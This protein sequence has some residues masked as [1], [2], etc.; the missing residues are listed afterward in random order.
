MAEH[1]NGDF[2]AT[3]L[4]MLEI[5]SDGLPHTRQELHRCL[6]DEEG[7][8]SN[9]NVHLTHMRKILARRGESIM[10]VE[11]RTLYRLVRFVQNES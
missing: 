3:E 10:C 8:L 5:L 7:P 2:T 11:G 4:K 1:L 9:I 6:Y